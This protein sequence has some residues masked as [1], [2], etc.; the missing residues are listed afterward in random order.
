MR[1]NMLI[2]RVLAEQSSGATT[3]DDFYRRIQMAVH[4]DYC[5]EEAI[6]RTF[7]SDDRSTSVAYCG[8]HREEALR[9]VERQKSKR[10]NAEAPNIATVLR[11]TVV[12]VDTLPSGKTITHVVNVDTNSPTKVTLP[13][14]VAE[15]LEREKKA[16]SDEEAERWV[17]RLWDFLEPKVQKLID[18]SWDIDDNP[19]ESKPTGPRVEPIMSPDGKEVRG[20]TTVPEIGPPPD[21]LIEKPKVDIMDQYGLWSDSAF[22]EPSYKPISPVSKK[23]HIELMKTRQIVKNLHEELED[24]RKEIKSMSEMQIQNSIQSY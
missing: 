15:T 10:D 6:G 12:G 20:Y 11:D 3:P 17:N 22:Q 19:N 21:H 2:E 13:K 4:C 5:N 24:V 9:E 7:L 1:Y 16:L 8:V 14:A 18:K 23:L